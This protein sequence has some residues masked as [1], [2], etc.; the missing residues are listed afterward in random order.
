MIPGWP[1]SVIA[2]LETGRT[3]WTTVLDALRLDPEADVAAVTAVQV[4]ELVIRLIEARQWRVGRS[5]RRLQ[6]RPGHR[7]LA[8]LGRRTHGRGPLASLG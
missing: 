1:Y 2:A 5:S 3:S 6:V 7:R 4:R 8:R